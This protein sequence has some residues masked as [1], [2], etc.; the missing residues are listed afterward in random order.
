MDATIPRVTYTNIDVDMT[1]LHHHLD[2]LIADFEQHM[3][4]RTWQAPFAGGRCRRSIVRS[5]TI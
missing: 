1:P 2:G 3:L 4:G 5:V